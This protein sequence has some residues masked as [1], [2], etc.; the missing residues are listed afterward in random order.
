MDQALLEDIFSASRHMIVPYDPSFG[1][2]CRNQRPCGSE[3]RQNQSGL[4]SC[5][6][7]WRKNV[8]RSQYLTGLWRAE[9]ASFLQTCPYSYTPIIGHIIPQGF[10]IRDRIYVKPRRTKVVIADSPFVNSQ[11]A[12]FEAIST[13]EGRIHKT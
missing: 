3:H 9:R 11:S 5:L 12:A 1:F 2:H 7:W 13:S 8:N 4:E 10:T 6:Q